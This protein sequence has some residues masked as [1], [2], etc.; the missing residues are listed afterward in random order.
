MEAGQAQRVNAWL[1]E[2]VLKERPAAK[3]QGKRAA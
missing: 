2:G 3:P 1:P